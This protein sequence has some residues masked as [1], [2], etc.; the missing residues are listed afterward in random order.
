M[1]AVVELAFE[2]VTK[3][4][5]AVIGVNDISLRL[6]PGITGLLGANGAGKS[7][8]LKLASGRLRPTQGR[9]RLG[10]HDARTVA[11][12]RLLAKARLKPDPEEDV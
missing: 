4:Y 6:G 3:F 7:T 1:S 11:A 2:H 12:K 5:G 10:D 8:L 9:V